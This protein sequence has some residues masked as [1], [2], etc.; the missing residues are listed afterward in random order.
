MTK[1]TQGQIDTVRE[2][3]VKRHGAVK[4]EWEIMLDLL[5]DNLDLLKECKKS[6]KQNGIYDPTTGKKNPLLSTE[7]DI[8]AT[9]IKQI[10]HLG[11]SLMPPTKLRTQTRTIQNFLKH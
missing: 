1:K 7:K 2:Y 10:Q 3:L 9:I 8:Q 11:I 6:I 4:P 5:S